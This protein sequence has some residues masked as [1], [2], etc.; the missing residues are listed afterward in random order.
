MGVSY[1]GSIA[2]FED[3]SLVYPILPMRFH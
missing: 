3:D 2:R 1:T